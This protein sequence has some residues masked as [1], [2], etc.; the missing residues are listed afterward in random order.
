MWVSELELELE[1]ERGLV[2]SHPTQQAAREGPS[3]IHD[4]CKQSDF[5][6]L[7]V[8]RPVSPTLAAG[9]IASE[10]CR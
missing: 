5:D 7:L 6:G 2:K 10:P 4:Q 9:P 1:H 3:A 8:G